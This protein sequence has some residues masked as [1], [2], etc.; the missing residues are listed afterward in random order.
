MGRR[1]EVMGYAE[2]EWLGVVAEGGLTDA[3]NARREEAGTDEG[4][5]GDII[6]HGLRTSGS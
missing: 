3:T 5:V 6:F 4:L 2:L 1:L